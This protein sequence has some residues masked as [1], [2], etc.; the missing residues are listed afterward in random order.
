MRA[1]SGRRG[2]SLGAAAA[3]AL[4]LYAPVVAA[5]GLGDSWDLLVR[6]PIEDFGDYQSL[7]FPFDYDGPLNTGS[8]GGFFPTPPRTCCCSTCRS[9][10][11]SAWRARCWC[12][13]C[14]SGA[15][16]GLRWRAPCSRSGWP[17]T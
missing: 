14:A 2:A 13:G 6:Y 8:I 10:W 4:L 7:P 3:A 11:C 5:A 1:S 17:T 15:S 16:A 9:R 12:S